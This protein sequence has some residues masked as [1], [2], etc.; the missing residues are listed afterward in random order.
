MNSRDTILHRIRT[1]LADRPEV[2]LPPACEVWPR[3]NPDTNTMLD[4]FEKE[5]TDVSGEMIRCGSLDDARAKLSQ[6]MDAESWSTLASVD[7]P[8]A[9]ALLDAM[10][11]EKIAWSRPNW[12]APTLADVPAGLVVA[13]TLL[14][15]T[16]S[17]VVACGTAQE[18]L[19]CYLPPTCIVLAKADQLAE[20]L[21]AAW[22]DL[23]Q[24]AADESTR[25]EFVIITGP[26]RTADIEKILILGVHGPKRLVVLLIE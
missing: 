9:H 15:D 17:C 26:S 12:E 14:A 22:D 2:P 13:D 23:A 4:R 11:S 20:H 3:E 7:K 18:R 6:L 21:P 19:L 10:P 24:R 1:A 25:G 16:G 8:A 5:L